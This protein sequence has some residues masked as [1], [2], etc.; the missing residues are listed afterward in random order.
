[1]GYGRNEPGPPAIVSTIPDTGNLPD[2]RIAPEVI[3]RNLLEAPRSETIKSRNGLCAITY[4][5]SQARH[6][7]SAIASMLRV[8]ARQL[9]GV[10]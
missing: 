7:S 1:M 10:P 9:C 8:D 2:V 3:S 5:A 6:E 4:R